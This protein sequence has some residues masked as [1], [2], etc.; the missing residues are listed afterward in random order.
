MKI[1]DISVSD[2]SPQSEA[3]PGVYMSLAGSAGYAFLFFRNLKFY[4]ASS[5]FTNRCVWSGC[6]LFVGPAFGRGFETAQS[7]QNKSLC[8]Q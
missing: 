7:T 5:S 2:G 6:G 1:K 8:V 4:P 3:G